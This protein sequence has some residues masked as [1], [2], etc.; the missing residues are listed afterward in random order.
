MLNT[1]RAETNTKNQYLNIR[2]YYSIRIGKFVDVIKYSIFSIDYLPYLLNGGLYVTVNKKC[3]NRL[4]YIDSCLY[5]S[6]S[7]LKE[8]G[9]LKMKQ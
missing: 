8:N 4:H 5:Q 1:C 3:Q 2:R 9:R 7:K 6:K